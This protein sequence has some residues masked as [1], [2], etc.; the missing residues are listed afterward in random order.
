[1]SYE[2][3]KV[4]HL[5]G[6]LLLFTSLGG[7]AMLV[8][9]GGTDEAPGLRKLMIALHGAA[10]LVIFVAGFGL[11]ARIGLVQAGWPGWIWA[12]LGVWVVLGAGTVLIRRVPAVGKNWFFVLPVLGALAAYFAVNKPF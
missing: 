12:K 5:F 3:Y 7:L 2:L 8:L 6:I 9:R 4:I 11:M 1:M 10:L